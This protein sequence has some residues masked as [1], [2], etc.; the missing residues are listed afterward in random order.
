MVTNPNQIADFAS[1]YLRP[2]LTTRTRTRLDGP[3]VRAVYT[4]VY[5]LSVHTTR[6]HGPYNRAVCTGRVDTAPVH[7]LTDVHTLTP[8]HPYT[9]LQHVRKKHCGQYFFRTCRLYGPYRRVV[10]TEQP[11]KRAVHPTVLYSSVYL[12]IVKVI[13]LVIIE[14]KKFKKFSGE[15]V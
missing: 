8:V 9:P 13:I 1:M 7:T 5:G 11:Y 15:G 14:I 3:F 4:G 2:V 6:A 10:W 12:F